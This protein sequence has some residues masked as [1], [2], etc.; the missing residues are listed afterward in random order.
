MRCLGVERRSI[1]PL[2]AAASAVLCLFSTASCSGSGGV[3][4]AVLNEQVTLVPLLR[5]GSVGWCAMQKVTGNCGEATGRL[6]ILVD[7]STDYLNK[8][9]DGVKS[10]TI[11]GMV[12]ATRGVAAVAAEKYIIL[13]HPPEVRRERWLAAGTFPLHNEPGLPDGLRTAVVAIKYKEPVGRPHSLIRFL[14]LNANGRQIPE[15]KAKSLSTMLPVRSVSDA[16]HPASGACRIDMEPMSGVFAFGANVIETVT[17]EPRLIGHAFIACASTIYKIGGWRVEATVLIDAAHP[18]A[19]PANL[20]LMKPL[21]GHSGVIEAWPEK[22][23]PVLARRIK[24]GWLVVYEGRNLA[25]RLAVLDHLNA[26]IYLGRGS[27]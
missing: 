25:E 8:N 17:P 10:G 4:A 3:S 16:A 11:E 1:R 7:V 23:V 24:G 27:K 22:N 2:V 12:V 6:P 14:P 13:H 5:A 26:S 15:V 18:G 19:R 21:P 9:G 20:P